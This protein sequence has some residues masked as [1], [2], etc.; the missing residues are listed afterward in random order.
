MLEEFPLYNEKEL[1][2][3][4]KKKFNQIFNTILLWYFAMADDLK[5]LEWISDEN[6]KVIAYNIA[7]L[8]LGNNL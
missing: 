6:Q 8:L 3:I 5:E 4:S 2:D 1:D 7:F